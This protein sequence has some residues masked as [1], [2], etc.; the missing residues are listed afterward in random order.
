MMHGPN[1]CTPRAGDK[2]VIMGEVVVDRYL[3]RATEDMFQNKLKDI[4][5][6]C[7]KC[8]LHEWLS[9]FSGKLQEHLLRHGSMDGYTQWIDDDEEDE[10]I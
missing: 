5:C 2:M 7:R 10:V 8:K 4:L 3:Q 6:P 1:K 9:P